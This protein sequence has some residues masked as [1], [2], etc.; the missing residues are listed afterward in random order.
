[1]TQSSALR[2][3]GSMDKSEK[4]RDFPSFESPEKSESQGLDQICFDPSVDMS[5]YIPL[6]KRGLAPDPQLACASAQSNDMKES[7]DE[8]LSRVA[9]RLPLDE[10]PND[11][12]ASTIRARDRSISPSMEGILPIRQSSFQGSV[13]ESGFPI[14]FPLTASGEAYED[15]FEVSS[16]MGVEQKYLVRGCGSWFTMVCLNE[17]GHHGETYGNVDMTGKAYLERHQKSCHR[18][19]C[20]ICWASWATREKDKAVQRLSAF[21]L[22]G[23]VL[24]PIHVTVSIPRSD[25]GLPL[26]KIREKMYKA[27]KRVGM[28]G[29]MMIIHPRRWD[30]RKQSY[31][32]GHS[33]VIGY[34]WI[35][36][37]RKNYV[38]SGY[39]VK[40]LRIR[41]TVE[42]TIFYQLS[43]CGISSEHH[44][45]TWF[46]ALSY[47]KLKVTYVEKHS[48][49]PVCGMELRKGL[50]VGGIAHQL[51]NNDG[52]GFYDELVNW[53]YAPV[54][55]KGGGEYGE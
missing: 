1:M 3:S 21:K 8:Y 18:P 40:N 11:A 47:N 49:C 54:R 43:H 53:T 38:A 44:T 17:R 19:L 25:Y 34:G 55:W 39:I 20:P 50:Y 26:E 13:S 9:P 51:E 24:K 7:L 16:F 5:G 2:P 29:G 41:K 22:K 32:S 10:V 30:A 48:E 15:H 42:G 27:L 23:R 33:H 28:I 6:A 35:Q 46:G 52:I 45:I 31:F 36:D 37:V 4:Q 14:D 12:L